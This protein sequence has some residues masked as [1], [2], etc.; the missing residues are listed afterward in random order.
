MARLKRAEQVEINVKHK[1]HLQHRIWHQQEQQ[2]QQHQRQ[3]V[4]APL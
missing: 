1:L 2:Q 3:H 4:I